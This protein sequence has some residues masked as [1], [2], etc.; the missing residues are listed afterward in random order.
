MPKPYEHLLQEV[1]IDE[2]TL[3]ARIPVL[4]AEINRDYAGIKP[5]LLVCV[6][7]GGVMFLTDLIRH[8]DIPHAI[9][10]MALSSY[11]LHTRE[12][13]GAVRIDMDL[14]Q[15][16]LG[17]H[18]LIVE[19][20]VDSGNT[21]MYLRRLL[22]ARNPASIKICSLLS[23]PSR[24]K[25]QIDIDYLGFDIPDKFVFG[26]GLDLDQLYRNL[27]FIGVARPDVFG[28]SS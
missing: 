28:D 3:Q 4:A 23:K 16:I 15:D 20:I 21:L 26:Y 9:D 17:Q 5:L 1:L 11:E 25:V 7:K 19:D 13:S 27:P 14:Q 6:L 18:I 12:S 22:A 2:A 8:I 24:R 10:F